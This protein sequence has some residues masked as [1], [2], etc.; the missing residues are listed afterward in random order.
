MKNHLYLIFAMVIV[1]S[2]VPV[3][4]L[5][6]LDLPVY[7]TLSIRFIVGSVFLYIFIKYKGIKFEGISISNL[8]LIGVQALLGAVLFNYFLLEGLKSISAVSSGILIGTLPVVLLVLSVIILKERFTLSK[9]LAVIVAT[10]GVVLINLS[11]V[12]GDVSAT[13]KGSLLVLLAV[14]CEALFL[15]IRKKLPMQISSLVLSLII[16]VY[17]FLFFVPFGIFEVF[18]G[19]LR[20]IDTTGYLLIAY[21][22]VFI[23]AIA[24]ILWFKGIKSVDGAYASVYT[25]FM[26]L[27]AVLLSSVILKESMTIMHIAGFTL[28]MSAMLVL[29][30]KR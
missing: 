1:G 9:G 20:R 24:Y 2:S 28:V 30:I 6:I 7:L 10:I 8:V 29:S 13:I 27:S 4:K 11:G 21:Y 18:H 12:E 15:L 23:T 26:P 3:G 17:G 14:I 5:V 19:G 22:G 25:A 16:S